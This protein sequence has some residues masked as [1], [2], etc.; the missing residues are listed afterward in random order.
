MGALK[1]YIAL[2]DEG[3]RH[4][5]YCQLLRD[6]PWPNA[7]YLLVLWIKEEVVV[8]TA[9]HDS[10]E[11]RT[12]EPFFMGANLFQLLLLLTRSSNDPGWTPEQL[13]R[14]YDK[15][16]AVANFLLFLLLRGPVILGLCGIGS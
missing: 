6:C 11:P 14:D 8:S 4:A 9:A 1:R 2:F 5:L 13:G 15:L 12:S 7:V 10:A 3:G 16:A